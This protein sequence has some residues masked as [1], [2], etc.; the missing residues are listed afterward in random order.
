M[1]SIVRRT[2]HVRLARLAAFGQRTDFDNHSLNQAPLVC[3]DLVQ[4]VD[5][6]LEVGVTLLQI[7]ELNINVRIRHE[8][9]NFLEGLGL[10][11][12]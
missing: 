1:R 6:A 2:I 3:N 9:H 7:T 10:P 4:L 5:L 8:G 12:A 11:G